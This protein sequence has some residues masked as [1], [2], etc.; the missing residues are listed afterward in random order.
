ME[1]KITEKPIGEEVDFNYFEIVMER[2]MP[3]LY[4]IQDNLYELDIESD[5]MASST[6]LPF[7]I[8]YSKD[9][10]PLKYLTLY[11]AEKGYL[12]SLSQTFTFS[13]ERWEKALD[14]YRKFNM[15][16]TRLTGHIDKPERRITFRY[17][18][19][20]VEEIPEKEVL[21]MI[22]DAFDEETKSIVEV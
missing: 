8:C 16:F 17:T 1:I 4:Q 6:G 15:G 18:T 21:E 20:F 19:S 12:I 2:W 10:Q 9:D 11:D 13:E 22:F 3:V 7:L 14:V 5:V